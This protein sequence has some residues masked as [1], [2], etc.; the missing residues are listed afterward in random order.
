MGSGGSTEHKSL[1]EAPWLANKKTVVIKWGGSKNQQMYDV[2]WFVSKI[3]HCLG[4]CHTPYINLPKLTLPSS[5]PNWVLS[6]RPSCH[7]MCT[8]F[9]QTKPKSAVRHRASPQRKLR[10]LWRNCRQISL[11]K[12]GPAWKN[13]AL[14]LWIVA[15]SPWLQRITRACCRNQVHQSSRVLW[16]KSTCAISPMEAAWVSKKNM[17]SL[18][19]YS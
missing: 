6:S 5:N 9:K 16:P 4:W 2:C 3:M 14:V 1:I 19:N 8:L 15:A 12:S 11:Q 13:H 18:R 7:W 10:Q 17:P